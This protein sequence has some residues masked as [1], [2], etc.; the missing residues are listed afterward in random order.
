MA[1]KQTGQPIKLKDVEKLL[2]GQTA[3]ILSAVDE[4]L[5]VNKT[6]ILNNVDKKLLAM[7]IRMLSAMDKKILRSEERIN[8][9]IDQLITTLDKFLKRLS[10]MED[11]FAAMKHDLNRVKTILKEKLGINLT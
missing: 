8:Q 5:I 9:K 3:V 4:R 10:D 7:E 1:K 6:D 11:E 2:D